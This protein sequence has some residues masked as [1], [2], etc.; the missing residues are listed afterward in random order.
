VAH[1]LSF[2]LQNQ[3]HTVETMLANRDHGIVIANEM[4]ADTFGCSNRALARRGAG[5]GWRPFRIP[6]RFSSTKDRPRLSVDA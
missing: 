3:R 6:V 5:A 1:A 2:G 4:A